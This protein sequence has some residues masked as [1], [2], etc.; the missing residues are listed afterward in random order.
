MGTKND[1][2]AVLGKAA[3]K[4]RK[5]GAHALQIES[6]RKHGKRGATIVAWVTDETTHS[7]PSSVTEKVSGKSITIPVIAK[8]RERFTPE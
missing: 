1:A 8:R 3:E 5:A 4:L 2:N 6:G 7:V